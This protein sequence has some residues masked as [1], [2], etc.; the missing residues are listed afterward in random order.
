MTFLSRL[1]LLH[2]FIILA[3]IGL[4][5]SALPTF[6]YMRS[7]L[8]DIDAA[9]QEARGARPLLALNQAVQWLQ[10]HR[11]LSAGMLGGDES[12][13]ARRPA[14][15]DAA[16]RAMDVVDAR[17]TEAGVPAAQASAW[18]EVRQAWRQ[19]EP[20]VAQRELQPAQS[21]A[22][23]TALIAAVMRIE[24]DLLH[25]YGL[26][27]DA[28]PD[29]YA[30]IQAALVQAPMLGEKLGVLRAQGTGFLGRGELPAQ[31]KGG[32]V[33]LRQRVDELEG[34][35]F[36]SFARATEGNPVFRSGL[37]APIRN[38]HEQI[39]GALRLADEAL[40]DAAAL[41]HP[42]PAYFDT[43]TRAIEALYAV[44]TQALERLDVTLQQRIAGLRNALIVQAAVLAL[45][46]LLAGVL[47][48]VFVR[49]ITRPLGQAVAL[50]GAVAQ[51]DL[52][53]P[54]IPHGSDE[55][56][57]LIEALLHMRARL[58]QVVAQVRSGA[59]GVATAST[60]IAQGNLDL[61]ARTESQASALEETAASM[62]QMTATVRQNA[63][64]A[65]QASQLAANASEVAAQ[66]G[67]V[68]A[69]VVQTMHGIH[70]SSGKIADIIGVIDG[71]AFQTNILALNAAV[72][73]ARAG[74]QGRGFAVVAGE[75]RSLAQRSAEAARE[76][77]ALISASVDSVQQGNALVE[78]AGATMQD[79][80]AAVRRVTDIM[81]EISAASREQSQGV[82]QVGEAVTQMD[83]ATQQNAALVE[84]M[85]A[86][87]S[88]LR[89]QAQELVQGVA[90][91]RL[92]A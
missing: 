85:A 36:R 60:Q 25:G 86:A 58:T 54:A 27:L 91:F 84:E 63:D 65:A 47:M 74:E 2:K 72:E 31:A 32:L 82:A 44:D 64:S 42:A 35:V 5:M 29:T 45:T 71:I 9:R 43:F 38:A 10:V 87:A 15:R 78:R 41:S 33:A 11:G 24:D 57:R 61:S 21:T 30:L 62:E 19:L 17:F 28:N 48:A 75:V 67:E 14:A 52:S 16:V 4:L 37:A 90:V 50:A 89:G 39:A 83:Q 69:Q 13:A 51:G 6:M 40:I 20:A 79:V 73:A 68:V 77:K 92:A 59:E 56:G 46:L 8:H 34:E 70:A 49:S 80:V 1:R 53:G 18:A 7:A 26:A 22:R 88:S 81:G 76:I 3:C 23:H 12:L 55:A 66:G